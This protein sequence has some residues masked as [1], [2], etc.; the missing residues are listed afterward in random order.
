M[1]VLTNCDK[2]LKVYTN[3]C[4]NVFKDACNNA[5]KYLENGLFGVIYDDRNPDTNLLDKW[6]KEYPNM[7]IYI[8]SPLKKTVKIDD[9]IHFSKMMSESLY[10]PECYLSKLEVCDKDALYFV[11]TRGGTGGKNVNIYSYDELQDLD[12][13]FNNSII[14]KCC[15]KNPDLYNNRNYKIRQLALI[16]NKDVYLH[17]ESWFSISEIDYNDENILNRRFKYVINQRKDVKFELSHKLTNFSLIFENI[18]LAINDFK[19]YYKDDINNFE[20]NEYSILGF[21]FVV[22]DNK[23]I[24]IIEINHRP[25]F[26]HPL[27]VREICD[28]GFIKDMI[29]LLANKNLENTKFIKI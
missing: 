29:I 18:K 27:N 6:K 16:H 15:F 25:Y 28:I 17:K 20:S 2:L 7:S 19:K 21:D 1:S 24:Q 5:N 14:Q 8:I 10:T 13:K 11:K 9:K 22:N 4:T 26:L 3:K 23:D 12:I